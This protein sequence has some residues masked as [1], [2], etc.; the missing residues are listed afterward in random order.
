MP[1]EAGGGPRPARRRR[2]GPLRWWLR[3]AAALVLLELALQLASPIYRALAA[4]D[5]ESASPDAPLTVLC[6]GDSHTFGLGEPRAF[7][8]PDRLAALLD[9][10][11]TAPVSV[12]NRGVPG[13]N[14]AQVA[15][16]LEDDLRDVDPEIV[17]LLT[18]INDTW[19]R[20][21]EAADTV[22]L[23]GRLKLV[24]LVR[25]LFAGVTTAGRF[26]VRSDKQGRI[27]VDRGE[28][29]RPV[30]MGAGAV[31]VRAGGELAASVQTH[32]KH[33]LDRVRDHDARPILMTYAEFQGDFATVNQA[34]RELAQVEGV[35]LVD[36]ERDFAPLFAAQGYE[37]LMQ[38]D[39]HPNARGYALMA[40]AIDRALAEAGWVPP[41]VEPQPSEVA[42]SLAP[43]QATAA[44]RCDEEGRLLLSGPPDWP[45]QLL[46]AGP[47]GA[48]G[49]FDVAGRHIP[50]QEDALLALSRIEPTFSGRL[51]SNG[52]ARIVVPAALRQAG[53]GAEWSACLV[54]LSQ[55]LDAPI[56]AVSP[57]VKIRF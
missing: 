31:G 46:I 45:F 4:R 17:L 18:G 23:L 3:V 20:D 42:P 44:L 12:V 6:V 5:N 14:S 41:A 2:A 53:A 26:E 22:S 13:F 21:S 24:R 57:A 37:S 30:N 36:H 39:H 52:T 32:L 16:V 25:V 38:N 40:A 34:V 48:V 11:F 54:L 56:A 10:R 43:G 7:S 51:D 28:G 15:A 50:L 9:R 1:S 35:R 27:V 49:G 29:E 8:Y 55:S 19:N 33:A 47:A